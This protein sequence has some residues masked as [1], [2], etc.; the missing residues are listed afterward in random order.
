MAAILALGNALG[1]DAARKIFRCLDECS[2][3]GTF[4][5]EAN[6]IA[7][8]ADLEFPQ[9]W[10]ERPNPPHNDFLQEVIYYGSLEFGRP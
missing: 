7:I 2:V 3:T 4:G 6:D 5:T 10:L 8:I 9:R 1:L